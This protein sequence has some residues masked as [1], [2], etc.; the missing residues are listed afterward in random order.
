MMQTKK[1]NLMNALLQERKDELH[2][3]CQMYR[4]KSLYAFG[5]VVSEKMKEGSDVDFLVDFDKG[6]SIADYTEN[7]FSLHDKL[8]ELFKRNVDLITQRSLSNPYFIKSVEQTKLL[9]Y[10]S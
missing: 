9:L 4:V 6:L 8:Q 1:E 3:L 2:R 7:Y 10:A 5:S